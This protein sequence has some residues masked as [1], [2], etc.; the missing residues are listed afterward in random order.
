MA[1]MCFLT[2]AWLQGC[3]VHRCR[4]KRGGQLGGGYHPKCRRSRGMQ[5]R[6]EPCW[7]CPAGD[8]GRVRGAS[9]EADACTPSEI[10]GNSS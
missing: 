6:K 7:A 9:L 3:C 5:F 10:T 1:S 8:S 2:A 4:K